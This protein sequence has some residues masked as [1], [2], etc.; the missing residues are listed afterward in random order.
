MKCKECG[1]SLRSDHGDGLILE[2]EACAMFLSDCQCHARRDY[3]PLRWVHCL[4]CERMHIER[5]DT[6]KSGWRSSEV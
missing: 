2:C 1:G 4:N 3:T 5:I 6:T